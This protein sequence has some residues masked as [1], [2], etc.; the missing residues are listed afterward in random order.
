MAITK[1]NFINYVRCPRYLAL[2]DIKKEKLTSSV[3]LEE[4]LQEEEMADLNEI[5]NLM[6]D[7]NGEDLIDTKNEQME[8][9]LPFYNHVE[10]LAGKLASSYFDGTF[11]YSKDT[12]KQESFDALIN[13]IRYLCYV[14][15]YNE[16]GDTFRIIEVKATTSNQYLSLGNKEHSIF[17]KQR[18]GTYALLEDLNLSI[19]EWMDPKIYERERGKLLDKYTSVGHYV[20]DLAVQ[21]YIIEHDLIEHGE[22][23]KIDTI[24]YYLAVLNHRYVLPQVE[25]IVTYPKDKNGYDVILYLDMTSVTKDLQEQIDR[26]R[27][28]IEQYLQ[29][30][31]SKPYPIGIYCEKK[32]TTKCKFIPVCW[33]KIPEKNSIFAYLDQHYGFQSPDGAKHT[34]FELANQGM[35]GMLDLPEEYL[36]REKNRIQR[37]VVE[38]H[39]V[40]QN[41]KKIQDGLTQITYPLYHLDFETFNSPLPRFYGESPYTQSVFQFSL[42]IEREPGICE[43]EKDHYGYLAPDHLDHRLDLVQKLCEWIDTEKGGTILVYNES[44]EKTRLKEL[45]DIFPEYRKP[46]LKMRDMIFDLM[47]VLR[48]NRKLYEELGYDSEEAK[49]FNYYHEEMNGSFSIKKI[50]PLFSNLTYKGME[51]SNGTEAMVTY[52]SFPRLEPKIYEYK[53]QKLVE[54]CMQDTWAMVEIL[55][56]LRKVGD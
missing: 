9:M 39:Q 43:K 30:L 7:S 46:L 26:D 42:H 40:Y 15:I 25:D 55:N 10:L 11:L 37:E 27:E 1:T 28:N 5:T 54:Y 47:Y 4:Y 41:A 24:S 14:D 3:S 49:R 22:E 33:K 21:R 48:G 31:D 29:N 45:A 36:T 53:Y 17:Q 20:Y 38:K 2:E 56:G 51:V 12:K 52:A 18:N 32:K 8:I 13:G 6:I 23:E 16:V 19:E 34:T 35:V 50:L 44:F